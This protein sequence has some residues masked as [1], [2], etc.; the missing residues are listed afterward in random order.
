MMSND[1]AGGGGDDED[2]DA[3]AGYVC[4]VL[5]LCCTALVVAREN[6]SLGKI[7]THGLLQEKIW[8][9]RNYVYV[10]KWKVG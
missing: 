3:S 2:E 7:A 5:R 9:I 8:K 10:K 6:E 1:D 4:A